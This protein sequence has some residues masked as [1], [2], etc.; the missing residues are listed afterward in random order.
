MFY[1]Q[2]ESSTLSTKTILAGPETIALAALVHACHRSPSTDS[3]ITCSSITDGH[4]VFDS[5]TTIVAVKRF[6]T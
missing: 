6:G 1:R 2:D 4:V 3:I 5:L